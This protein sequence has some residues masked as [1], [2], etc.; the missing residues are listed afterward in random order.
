LQ[1]VFVLTLN[2]AV[3]SNYQVQVSSDLQN[4]T[5]QGAAFT[6]TNTYWRSTNFWDVDQWN[7]LFFRLKPQ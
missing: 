3:G 5:N 7:Q 4:W 6:A 2:L 1:W